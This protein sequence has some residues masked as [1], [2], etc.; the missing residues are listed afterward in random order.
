MSAFSSFLGRIFYRIYAG[1][2]LLTFLTGIFSFILFKSIMDERAATY[3]TSMAAGPAHLLAMRASEYSDPLDRSLWL[4]RIADGFGYTLVIKPIAEV[5]FS[6]DESSRLEEGKS[7]VRYDATVQS[8]RI[9]QKIPGEPNL[10]TGEVDQIQETQL[11]GIASIL[12]EDFDQYADKAAHIEDLQAYFPYPLQII[13]INKLEFDAEQ[14][15]RL[16]RKKTVILFNEG[17]SLST[18]SFKMVIPLKSSTD[19]VMAGPIPIFDRA[20][21]DLIMSIAALGLFILALGLYALIKPLERKVSAI[22]TAVT[23]IRAGNLDA[24]AIVE[25]NDEISHLASTFNYMTTHIKRLIT[26]QR[27]LTR[28]ISHEL[29][30]PVARVRFAVDMLAD[31]DDRDSRLEQTQTIDADIQELDTLIDEI[32]THARLEESMPTLNLQRVNLIEMAKQTI[33]E[34]LVLTD[35]VDI[36]LTNKEDVI[37]AHTDAKYIKRVLQN[38]LGNGIRHADS[39]IQV[40]IGQNATTLWIDVEDDGNG[41]DEV[42]RK[43]IFD[44]FSRLDESRN[45]SLGNYGLGL[46]IVARIAFWFDGEAVALSSDEL[47]G[48][49]FSIRWPKR[50]SGVKKV[51]VDTIPAAD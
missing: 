30:T 3:R 50:N 23:R 40:S 31:T 13:S 43:R 8:A 33:L 11:R 41:V 24:K 29:R 10:I 16:Q 27:E 46:S 38:F 20:P 17:G 4:R 7:V 39:Q 12:Q 47:G 36:E 14:L 22:Q 32:L 19:I 21:L 28:A 44:P 9:F 1:I 2:I 51:S 18:S 45:R 35:R 5:G 42:D 37:W 48:A 26:S 15:E 25:G 34:T 49:K 6:S